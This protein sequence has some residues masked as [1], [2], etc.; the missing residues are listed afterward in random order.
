M[1]QC[2]ALF[3]RGTI[4]MPVGGFLA[5]VGR[6]N[7]PL[8][9]RGLVALAG[10]LVERAEVGLGGRYQGVRIGPFGGE[11]TSAF[12]KPNR[13][14][15]LRIGAAGYRVHLIKFK[16]RIVWHQRTYRLEDRVH[17]SVAGR[18]RGDVLAV[19]VKG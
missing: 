5:D 8:N 3:G 15:R 19:D 16:R 4:L 10:Q 9:R 12:R 7:A 18:L 17:R 13:Y 11:R 2:R 14:F 1:T 6:M